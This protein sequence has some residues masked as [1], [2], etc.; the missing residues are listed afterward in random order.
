MLSLEEPLLRGGL[1]IVDP[2]CVGVMSA[3]E[4]DISKR[5]VA[6]IWTAVAGCCT[7]GRRVCRRSIDKAGLNGEKEKRSKESGPR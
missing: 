1:T 3:N 4:S 5:A 7:T 2:D 6:K